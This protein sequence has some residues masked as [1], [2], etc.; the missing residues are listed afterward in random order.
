M[1]QAWMTRVGRTF[2]EGLRL[3]A[4]AENEAYHARFEMPM[5]AAGLDQRETMEQASRMG[6]DFNPLVDRAL[7]AMYRRQQELAW[8][9]HLVEHIEVAL[10]EAGVLGRPERVPA[11]CFLDLVGYTRLTEERGDQAA[12]DLAGLLAVLVDRSSR[13]QGGVPVKWL[14]DGVM[15]HFWDPAGAAPAALGM[16]EELPAAGLPPAHVG[17]AAGPVVAQ[18]GDYFGRTVNLAARIAARASAGQVLV[19][20]RVVETAASEGMTFVE[21]G[22]VQLQ[23]IFR[24]V[25]LFEARRM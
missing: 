23:G 9:E 14:G 19:T 4:K 1:D 21:L 2:A 16:A 25:R 13:A 20:Q 12:A 7:L 6:G 18:G 24:P 10:E 5:L 22:D 17:V 8:T 3:A 15:F 11:M